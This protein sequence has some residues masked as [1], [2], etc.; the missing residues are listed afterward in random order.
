MLFY[1]DMT[2]GESITSPTVTVDRGEM[3]EFAKRW[4][5]MPF[6]ID[7]E[8]G[9]A[10]FG[11]ITAPGLFVLAIKQRLIHQLSDRHAVIASL[12]YDELR[13]HAPVRPDDTL[14][15]NFACLTRRESKSKPDRGVVTVRLSLINQAGVTVMSHLDTILVRRRNQGEAVK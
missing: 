14:R 11:G 2:P 7:D 15:L 9:K 6:H 13:F 8:A 4:D 12:G 5:P 3:I 10:A 1:E